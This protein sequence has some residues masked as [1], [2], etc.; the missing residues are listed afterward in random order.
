[1][2]G[3]RQLAEQVISG[4]QRFAEAERLQA[5]AEEQIDERDYITAD[6]TLGRALRELGQITPV[7]AEEIGGVSRLQARVERRA[8]R[9][10]RRVERAVRE[11]AE[12]QAYRRLCGSRP[13]RSNWDHGFGVIERTLRSAAHDP[14]SI[15]VENCSY[16][17]MSDDNCWQTDCSVRGNNPF[18]G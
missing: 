6:G 18:G 4:R 8:S 2:N 10:E 17:T 12:A 14:G 13:T 5:L 16:P 1:V 3:H 15:D 7:A 11:R 9:I